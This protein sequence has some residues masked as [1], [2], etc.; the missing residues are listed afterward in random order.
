MTNATAITDATFEQDVVRAS[1]VTVAKFTAEWCGPCRM[2]AP[3]FEALATARAADARFVEV[4]A[5]ASPAASARY[6]VRGLPTVLYFRDGALVGQVM[7]AV[8][9]P[10]LEAELDRVAG[11]SAGA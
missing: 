8:P 6:G 11:L 5:D 2:M 9:R 3:H 10:K 1:G 7:G 4:D